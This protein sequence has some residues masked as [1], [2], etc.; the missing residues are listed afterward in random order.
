MK[1]PY[2]RHIVDTFIDYVQGRL[3]LI[4]GVVEK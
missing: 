4:Q 1:K 2:K 3:I